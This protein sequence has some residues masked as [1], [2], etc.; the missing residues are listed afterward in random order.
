VVLAIVGRAGWTRAN[1]IMALGQLF[2]RNRSTAL[3]LGLVVHAIAGIVFAMI[4]CSA[5]LL[6]GIENRVLVIVAGIILGHLH[7]V[8]ASLIF[9]VGAVLGDTEG[10]I[11]KVQFSGG[12]TYFVAH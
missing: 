5:I 3:F 8:V 1:L 4:Y 12:P 10:E 6:I 7:G 2:S 9:V 11:K